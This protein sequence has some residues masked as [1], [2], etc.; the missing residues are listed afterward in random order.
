MRGLGA[1]VTAAISADIQRDYQVRIPWSGTI[2]DLFLSFHPFHDECARRVQIVPF[3]N[4]FTIPVL[5]PEDLVV[6]KVLFNRAKDWLDIEAIIATQG[7]KFSAPYAL[8]WLDEMLG[9]QD[10][11]VRR[12]RTLLA[13]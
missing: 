11:A 3:A 9:S 2:M 7:R 8:R 4:G 12:L 6:F 10:S 5:L 1:S 13:G